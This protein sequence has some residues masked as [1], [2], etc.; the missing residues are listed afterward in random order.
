[1]FTRSSSKRL[2]RAAVAGVL[3]ATVSVTAV[4]VAT[5]QPILTLSAAARSLAAQIASEI[6]TLSSQ[7]QS[8]SVIANQLAE[9]VL[10]EL[11][12]G[13]VKP[14]EA[15]QAVLDATAGADSTFTAPI[16]VALA[17]RL[18]AQGFDASVRSIVAATIVLAPEMTTD[19]VCAEFSEDICSSVRAELGDDIPTSAGDQPTA[20][21]SNPAGGTGG[22]AFNN[23]STGSL[24]RGP[25]NDVPTAQ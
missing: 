11:R 7:G 20:S 25:Q 15:V 24:D 19:S 5:A 21:T 8:S 18:D 6:A 12:R 4:S 22:G 17:D 16:L 1:M 13:E 3:A 2:V 14:A 23:N 10:S 9:S